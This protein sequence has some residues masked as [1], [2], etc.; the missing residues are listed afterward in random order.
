[1]P[2]PRG[3][4]DRILSDAAG[5]KAMAHA[6]DLAVFTPPH[7]RK[8][9]KQ[10]H[11]AQ[12]LKATERRRMVSKRAARI[13]GSFLVGLWASAPLCSAQQASGI[14][15]RVRETCGGVLPGVT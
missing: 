10:L 5:H 3:P 1:M 8:T 14:A 15:G 2:L 13:S 6:I 11:S 4:E 12:T 7:P 9:A